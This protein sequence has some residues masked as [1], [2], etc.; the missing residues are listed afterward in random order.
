MQVLL[1]LSNPSEKF[2]YAHGLVKSING[3]IAGFVFSDSNV[4]TDDLV[5]SQHIRFSI[6]KLKT[7]AEAKKHIE[8]TYDVVEYNDKDNP[9]LFL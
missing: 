5:A 1:E 6:G 9:E 7:L 4:T 8:A 3:N 2:K